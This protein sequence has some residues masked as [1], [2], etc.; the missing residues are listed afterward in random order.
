M[1]KALAILTI[2]VVFIAPTYEKK[3]LQHIMERFQ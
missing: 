3:F 1:L 2:I